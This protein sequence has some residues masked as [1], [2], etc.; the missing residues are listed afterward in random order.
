MLRTQLVPCRASHERKP[1]V[2]SQAGSRAA[3]CLAAVAW[4][5]VALLAGGCGEDTSMAT[6]ADNANLIFVDGAQEFQQKVLQS[7]KPVMVEFFKAKCPTCIV[8]EAWMNELA[9]EY[10]GRVVFAR[11]RIMDESF[12]PTCPE[13][14]NKYKLDWVPTEV[15]FVNGQE[16]QRWVFNHLKDEF[17]EPIND[18]LLEQG[19][20]REKALQKQAPPLSGNRLATPGGL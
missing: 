14:K 12:T 7:D 2:S 20:A 1:A 13:V 4:S 15:L 11:M 8:Q 17:R 10:K 16:K 19:R 6:T 18:V 3:C 5:A 9:E